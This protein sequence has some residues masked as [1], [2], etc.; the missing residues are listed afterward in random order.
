[1]VLPHLQI[2]ISQ[3]PP[4]DINYLVS[5]QTPVL[6]QYHVTSAT[7]DTDTLGTFG[8]YISSKSLNNFYEELYEIS[9]FYTEWQEQE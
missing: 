6:S 8:F 9:S 7:Y 4:Y 3:P 1:M 5:E 2:R